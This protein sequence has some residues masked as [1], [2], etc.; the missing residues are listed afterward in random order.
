MRIGHE[1]KAAVARYFSELWQAAENA[2]T[3]RTLRGR[4]GHAR[5][6]ARVRS[7]RQFSTAQCVGAAA[8]AVV[9]DELV[10]PELEEPEDEDEDEDDEPPSPEPPPF[11]V[12]P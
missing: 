5:S 7:R 1:Q 12:E 3:A 10:E 8:F 2:A 9:D 6:L 11:F 4:E